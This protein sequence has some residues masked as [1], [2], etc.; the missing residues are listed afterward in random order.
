M[1]SGSLFY[2]C[3][4]L[5]FFF[6]HLHDFSFTAEILSAGAVPVSFGGCGRIRA[7]IF[8]LLKNIII[9]LSLLDEDVKCWLRMSRFSAIL[10]R[11]D[12]PFR[13]PNYSVMKRVTI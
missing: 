10:Y 7:H 1:L 6:F 4:L 3:R 13:V 2:H 8:M 12:N 11:L 9:S 5:N